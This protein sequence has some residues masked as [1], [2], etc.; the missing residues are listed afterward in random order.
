MVG[1]AEERTSCHLKGTLVKGRYDCFRTAALVQ[2]QGPSLRTY[3]CRKY[4]ESCLSEAKSHPSYMEH[5]GHNI[6]PQAH[7]APAPPIPPAQHTH[8]IDHTARVSAVPR[9]HCYSRLPW[10]RKEGGINLKQ[11]KYSVCIRNLYQPG[12]ALWSRCFQ[13]L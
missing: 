10:S 9:S 8:L 5:L 11:A 2:S 1:R 3:I 13:S 4:P 12:W 7:L 6:S